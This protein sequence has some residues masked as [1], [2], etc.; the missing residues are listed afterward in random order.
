MHDLGEDISNRDLS[1]GLLS[2]HLLVNSEGILRIIFLSN[3]ILCLV[4]T[5]CLIWDCLVQQL[6]RL[7]MR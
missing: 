3:L 2:L 5:Y 4:R 6:T 1:F 7:S